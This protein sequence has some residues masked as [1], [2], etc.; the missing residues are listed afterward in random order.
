M[1]YSKAFWALN[2]TAKGLLPLFLMKREMTKS[3]ECK[4]EKN[5]TLTYLELENLHGDS[6]LSRSSI[7]RGIADLMAKGFIEIVHPGGAYQK[8]KTVYGLCHEWEFWEPG[9]VVRE[10][11][12]GKKVGCMGRQ[13]NLN[14]QSA[15]HT[16]R[17]NGTLKTDLGFHIATHENNQKYEITTP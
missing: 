8:D 13:E 14:C 15:T 1:A 9:R 4:N 6:G 17:Q 16:H 2:G 11:T 5:I 3:H 12:K 10:K 7:S